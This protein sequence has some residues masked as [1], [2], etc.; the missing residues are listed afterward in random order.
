MSGSNSSAHGAK[1]LAEPLSF[2]VHSVSVPA[3][4]HDPRR[5]RLGRL[6]MLLVLLVCAAPVVASYVAYFVVR[7]EARSN[8]GALIQPPRSMPA[9]NLR[10]L[11]G[12]PVTA[13]S[14][15]G[16][17]LLLVVAA[18]PCDPAC[19]RRLYAQRQFREML[20]RERERLDKVWLIPD[21]APVA[22]ALREALE[23]TPAMH[24]LRVDALAL[25]GWL[26]PEAGRDLADHL[27]LVDP[28][29]DWML[30]MPP[31][32]E[33]ARIKRDLERLLRASA[34]WD[35]PGR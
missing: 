10:A 33:P 9:L 27:Y 2:T 17:W 23:R 20:G 6:K 28:Q 24:I 30:R 21:G 8:Q 4:D 1:P 35:L 16:Q 26:A 11:D 19:E 15:K 22:P 13:A 3:S 7:P 12:A 34:S 25:S 32:A 29:G 31:D 5:T 18:A 14:L